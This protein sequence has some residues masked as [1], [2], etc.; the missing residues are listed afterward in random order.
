MRAALEGRA[1]YKV[2]CVDDGSTDDTPLRLMA[3]A[4]GV[5]RRNI[6]SEVEEV[7]GSET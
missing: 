7:T 4:R 2:L 3:E 1:E 5:P 6:H